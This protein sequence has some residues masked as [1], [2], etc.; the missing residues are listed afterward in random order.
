MPMLNT[1][2]HTSKN[3][4]QE[5]GRAWDKLTEGWREL[6]SRSSAALTHFGHHKDSKAGGDKQAGSALAGFPRWGLLAGEVEET[7]GE[8]VVRIELPGLDKQD[9]QVS[10]E[11]NLLQLRGEKR[12]ERET[13]NSTYHMMERAYGAFQRTIPLPRNVSVDHARASFSHGVLTVRLPKAEP[14]RAGSIQLS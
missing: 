1:L 3:L 5:I 12:F 6:L 2:S 14:G 13:H 11:G 8:V 4:G 9:C 10:I 7:A